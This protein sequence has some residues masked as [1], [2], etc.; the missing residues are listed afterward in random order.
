MHL[1][2]QLFVI[3]KSQNILLQNNYL[4]QFLLASMLA[5]VS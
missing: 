4:Q 5:H 2:M 3:I 1:V